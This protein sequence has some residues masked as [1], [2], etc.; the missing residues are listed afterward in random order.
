MF[1]VLNFYR[2]FSQALQKLY[3]KRPRNLNQEVL[4]TCPL[5]VVLIQSIFGLIFLVYPSN[6]LELPLFMAFPQN[7][8]QSGCYEIS[9]FK[10]NSIDSFALWHAWIQRLCIWAGLIVFGRAQTW[11]SISE[12]MRSLVDCLANLLNSIRT[13]GQAVY[14]AFPHFNPAIFCFVC[15][16]LKILPS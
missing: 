9:L 13:D 7:H 4:Q 11:V 10:L 12:Q 16:F 3:F 8:Y 1:S 15:A 5:N 6:W 14:S 2:I